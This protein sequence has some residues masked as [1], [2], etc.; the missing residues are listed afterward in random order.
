MTL[1]TDS[2]FAECNTDIGS[3]G[4]DEGGDAGACKAPPGKGCN[5]H[6]A[7][8]GVPPGAVRMYS[9]PGL[10]GNLGHADYVLAGDEGGLWVFHLTLVPEDE[11]RH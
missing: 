4:V 5:K 10:D 8:N 1:T 11:R 9:N 3:D 2:A 7:P 6:E